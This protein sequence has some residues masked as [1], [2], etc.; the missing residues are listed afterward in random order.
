[1]N[2]RKAS[3][4]D[5]CL[6]QTDIQV[7]CRPLWWWLF[8]H[9]RGF[10]EESSANHSPL[11]LSGDELARTNVQ[12]LCQDQSTVAQRGETTVDERSRKSCV[13]AR[14]PNKFPHYADGCDTLLRVL[15]VDIGGFAT[16]RAVHSE[17]NPDHWRLSF[18]A[19]YRPPA[20]G[21][22]V[23]QEQGGQE[24][25]QGTPSEE[26]TRGLVVCVRYVQV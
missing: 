23:D 2:T 6:C 5:V 9:V 7:S 18:P 15:Q 16:G 24:Q 21:P 19:V 17:R 12:S 8:P 26:R 25:P 20:A 14:F 4:T 1:M 10:W 3:V 13:R 22:Q 11:A